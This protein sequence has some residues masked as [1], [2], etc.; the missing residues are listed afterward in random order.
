MTTNFA[1]V[2]RYVTPAFISTGFSQYATNCFTVMLVGFMFEASKMGIKKMLIFFLVTQI[3]AMVFSILCESESTGYITAGPSCFVFAQLGG[4]ISLIVV[5]W[6]ALEQAGPLRICLI[7]MIVFILMIMLLI[8]AG[9]KIA[10][11]FYSGDI[12]GNLGGFLIGLFFGMAMVPAVRQ[13][14]RYAGS[15]EK[16]VT[17]VGLG[18]SFF[19]YALM[20]TL[21]Y[22]V[23][24]FTCKVY[25]NEC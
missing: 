16:L 15:Y 22:T 5:N 20:F 11:G 13:Q 17:K 9:S 12:F 19:F 8:S 6:Q 7:F 1:A 14:A 18:L 23:K 2:Y 4:L 3:G 21:T 10:I 24:T 25:Y